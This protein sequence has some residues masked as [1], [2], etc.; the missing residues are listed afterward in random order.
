MLAKVKTFIAYIRS[1]P[2]DFLI[3]VVFAIAILALIRL[4]MQTQID[5][6]WEQFQSQHNCKLIEAKG[7]NNIRTGWICDDGEEYYRW[8]QQR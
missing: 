4:N 8:R 7:G 2:I 1:N 3:I 6:N 5:D